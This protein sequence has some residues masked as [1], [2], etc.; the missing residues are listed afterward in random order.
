MNPI[1]GGHR[2]PRLAQ[3]ALVCITALGVSFGL[4][5]ASAPVSADQPDQLAEENLPWEADLEWHDPG[6]WKA[7]GL[8]EGEG[9]EQTTKCLTEDPL[10]EAISP[11]SMYQRDF[12]LPGGTGTE[13]GSALIMEFEENRDA[14]RVYGWLAEM[15]AVNCHDT[16]QLKGFTPIGPLQGHR[17]SIP[18]T[19]AR[20]TEVTYREELDDDKQEAFFESIGAVRDGNKIALV[21][22]TIWAMDSN[23]SYDPDDGT[24]LPMHPMY[25][26]MPK[27]ADRLVA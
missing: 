13:R 10:D 23:W 11:T 1:R 25:R 18:G 7:A 15:A 12:T 9:P 14:D 5:W 26:T 27:V 6:D 16:L 4:T 3:R 20:F 22:M 17:I 8:W 21:S 2:T 24:G 19:E